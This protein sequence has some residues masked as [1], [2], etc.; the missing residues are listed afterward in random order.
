[1]KG[2]LMKRVGGMLYPADAP[3]GE[4]LRRVPE[5]TPISV[6]LDRKRSAVQ[7]ALYWSVLQAVVDAT[8]RWRTADELHLA[9]KVATGCVDVVQLID[10]RMIKVPGSIAF[11]AMSQDEAQ[12]YYDAAFRVICDEV[13]GGMAVEDLLAHTVPHGKKIAA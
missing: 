6:H 13:M 1:M 4:A 8:G 7:L 3:S 2:L 12:A 9:L 11:D 10:G 5:R